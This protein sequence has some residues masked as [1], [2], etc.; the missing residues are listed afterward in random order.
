MMKWV[1]G[2][3]LLLVPASSHALEGLHLGDKAPAYSLADLSGVAHSLDAMGERPRV[4]LFWSTWSDRSLELL[5]DFRAF[6]ERWAAEGLAIVAVNADGEQLDSIRMQAVHECADRLRLPFPVL[7]D[8]GLRT[9]S[10]YGVLA[11]PSVVVVDASGRISYVLGGYPEMLREELKEKILLAMRGGSPEGVATVAAKAGEPPA[12]QP[13]AEEVS[14]TRCSIP[15]AFYCTMD[16]ERHRAASHSAIVAVRLSICRGNAEEAERMLESVS[17]ESIQSG[18]LRFAQGS[19]L[20]LKGQT[21]EARE[22][23]NALRDSYPTEG[24]G[25]W[26][27]GMTALAEGDPD[28]ALSHMVAAGAG[29]EALPEAETAVLKYLEEFWRTGRTAPHEDKFLAIFQEL[30]SVRAC[31]RKLGSPG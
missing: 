6:H 9:Y 17:R 29:R 11:L 20:L 14:A 3:L 7:L 21:T 22:A 24:W 27:L 13:A 19:L 30:D 1:L 5:Q 26:G 18:D 10:A 2:A 25:E 15:R 4:I 12:P 28:G 8:S 23:F 31:Y 16:A